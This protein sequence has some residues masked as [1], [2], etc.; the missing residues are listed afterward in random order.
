MTNVF[1]LSVFFIL[2]PLTGHASNEGLKEQLTECFDIQSSVQRLDCYDQIAKQQQAS[3]PQHA[4]GA[5]ESG[6][7]AFGLE[8]RQRKNEESEDKIFIEIAEKWQNA[9][10]RWR[11][12]TEDGQEWYQIESDT[13]FMFDDGQRYYIERGALGSFRLSH[14]GTNRVTRV[15]RAD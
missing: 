7:A 3:E 6:R 2:L 14:E 9:R 5:S 13:R 10:G 8:N 15:R 12:I 1:K 11:F 4:S